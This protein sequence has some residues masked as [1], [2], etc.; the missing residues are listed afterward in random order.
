MIFIQKV[1]QGSG[2]CYVTVPKLAQRHLKVMS[3]DYVVLIPQENNTMLIQRT[4]DFFNDTG[5]TSATSKHG[6]SA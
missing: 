2:F 5:N 1:A 3:Q 4:E 6:G